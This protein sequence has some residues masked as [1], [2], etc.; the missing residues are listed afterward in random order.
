M[1]HDGDQGDDDNTDDKDD[2]YTGH[3]SGG[4]FCF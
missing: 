3:S 2:D 4:S 1:V